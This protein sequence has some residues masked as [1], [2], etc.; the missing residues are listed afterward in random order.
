ML[1]HMLIEHALPIINVSCLFDT[2]F[3]IV[4]PMILKPSPRVQRLVI[5]AWPHEMKCTLPLQL[6]LI[7]FV[8]PHEKT[9]RGCVIQLM[10]CPK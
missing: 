9:A 7:V 5:L 8:F 1:C 10:H 4:F 6:T 3:G 2:S